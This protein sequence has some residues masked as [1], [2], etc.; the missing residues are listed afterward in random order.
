MIDLTFYK[1]K[2]IL[3]TGH[4]GFKGSWLC[5][6]LNYCGS[7]VYGYALKAEEKSLYNICNLDNKVTSY[8]G[9][10]RDFDYLLKVFEEI[11]PEIV[12]HLAAQAIVRKGYE[13]PVYTYNSN[14]MGTVNVLECIRITDSVRSFINVTTDKVYQPDNKAYV[15]DDIL[16]GYD[17]YSN[18]KSCSELITQTYQRSY[19][20][21]KDIAISTLRSGNVIGGGDFS[22][23]RI[24]ADCFKAYLNDED[25]I[26]RN[27][28]S[29]RPYQHVL[30]A[31]N[32]YLLINQK[33]YEDK[34]YASAYNIGPD[35]DD[36]INNEELVK[37]FID[38]IYELDKTKMNYKIIN[39]KGPHEAEYL[40]LDNSKIK[41]TLDYKRRWNINKTI[42]ELCN[43]VIKYKN[44]E[45]L[46]NYII[47]T[48]KRYYDE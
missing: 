28:L 8:I 46:S 5:E 12:F 14:T 45:D 34:S 1:N 39:D 11:K 13:D 38:K 37:L 33:Q 22:D 32:V 6:L 24:M 16:N 4:T 29:I 18:S 40:Y 47:D 19:F 35:I 23:D 7:D 9:D 2:K 26:I 17:P 44:K 42:D 43:F 27:P 15:E 31:L 41:R 3:V 36:Y 30:E 21:N 20:Y 10:I 25:I 48:I